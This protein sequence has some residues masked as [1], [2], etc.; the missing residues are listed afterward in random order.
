M[1]HDV[2][3]VLARILEKRVQSSIHRI[4]ATPDLATHSR[5]I[6]ISITYNSF[7]CHNFVKGNS[8][9]IHVLEDG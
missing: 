4:S 3:G 2:A 1:T 8:H 5:Q 6:L 7:L 9:L